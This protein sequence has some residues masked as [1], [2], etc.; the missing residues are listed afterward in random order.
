MPRQRPQSIPWKVAGRATE[1]QASADEVVQAMG[2][3]FNSETGDTLTLAEFVATGDAEVPVFLDRFGLLDG[4]D[5]RRQLVEIGCGIGRMTCAFTRRF[6]RVVACDLDAGFLERC[7]EAVARYGKVER[8]RTVEVTDGRTLRLPDDSGDVAFSYITLQHCRRD[9]ALAL[10]RE[11]VRVV[12]PGGQVALNFRS[13]SGTDPFVLPV[14][15]AMRGMLRAPGVGNWLS[16]RRTVTR[17]AWQANRLDPHQVVGPI[18]DSLTD[19]VVWR[20]PARDAPLWGVKHATS[21]HFEGINRNHWWL[22]ATV[23]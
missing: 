3:V 21:Q 15:V 6:G 9:D 10:V 16:R 4:N 19:V 18:Q 12:R 1:E 14:G 20:N 22:V 13:W 5:E 7:R 8:L 23:R 17:L 11:A 2:W